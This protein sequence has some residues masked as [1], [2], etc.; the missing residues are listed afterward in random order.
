MI[1]ISRILVCFVGYLMIPASCFPPDIQ[2]LSLLER[3]APVAP[4]GYTPAVVS[5]PAHRPTIRAA[6]GLS[7]N[8]TD[9][10]P[11]R[12]SNTVQA[13]KDV[14]SRANITGLDTGRYIDNL[15]NAG[16]GLPRVAIA[17][18]G[19]GY[20]ALMNGA[21]ALAAFDNRSTNA[22]ETG[23][24]GGLLQSA[25]YLSGLSGGSWLVGSLYVQNFTSVES[26]IFAT[27]GFLSTIWQFDHSILNGP[28]GLSITRYYRQLF[29]DV[30][31]KRDAG[32]NTT[33]TDYWGRALSYQL[34][35]PSD[36]GPAFTFSSISNDTDFVSAQTPL[37]LIVAIERT[38][39]QLQI[40]SNSTVFEF[41]PWEMGSY[42]PGLE[43]FAPLQF[44]GSN[45]T[46]GTIPR[47]GSCIAGVDNAGFV[48]GTSS[49]LFNQ[50]FLQIGRVEG[51]PEFLISAINR[52]L[53]NVGSEN[54]DIA[55]WPNPFFR[56]NS[57]GNLNANSTV[58]AL[59][60]GGE[61]LQNIPLHPLLLEEREVDVIFA[62]D[63]SADT[64]T[65]WPN[66]TAMVA[67]FNRSEARV[68][69][70][71]SRFPDV[72]DQNTFVNLGLNQR[73]TFFGCTNGSNTPRGPLIVYM[74]NAP[75]S[76]QSN[77]STFDLEYSDEE[78]NQI[79][80]NGYNM[81]TMGNGTVDSNWPACIGCAILARSLVRTRTRIPSKCADC[82]ARYCWNGTTNNTLP[83]TYE[84]AQILAN[85][86]EQSTSS[87]AR[88]SGTLLLGCFAFML[89]I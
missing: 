54:R 67:T 88:I 11:L 76:F 5:C 35:D 37:P 51:V 23:H 42:D 64:E 78:R 63:G 61:D 30:D 14:L 53:A 60:D 17:I 87:A 83:N 6:T 81:A 25:T 38:S 72:P 34:V 2:E 69:A 86:T 79:I 56:Y 58:L 28:D 70:N 40:A 73:P 45:F 59:V 27:E 33:I 41:N 24:L 31:G 7:T 15:T 82:F 10:L 13:M 85:T 43:A 75:Y 62:V 50:A 20:R 12:T 49:S 71:D 18:S 22:T 57:S 77:V 48:M 74:P 26:I 29:D 9:W 21:G 52:T 32:F 89:A 68:S 3:A 65:L 55:N 80:Q 39:G 46:N 36:G 16:T 19:G 44:V 1:N 66:G 84:P 47:N 4:D 8:E